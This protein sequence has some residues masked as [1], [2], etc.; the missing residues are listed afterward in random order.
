MTA[1]ETK[2]TLKE[3]ESL[4]KA[5]YREHLESKLMPACNG[6]WVAIAVPENE[7]EVDAHDYTAVERLKA[8]HPSKQ[9]F[10]HGI[11]DALIPYIPIMPGERC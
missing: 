10:L 1:V 6:M 9:I 4:A 11:G 8:R 3:I 5:F 2:L 7:Y